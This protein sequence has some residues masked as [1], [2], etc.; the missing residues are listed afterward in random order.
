MVRVAFGLIVFGALVAAR[1]ARARPTFPEVVQ[2]TLSKKSEVSEEASDICP[3]PCSLCHT[4]TPTQDNPETRF[5]LN[6]IEVAN[7]LGVPKT[8]EQLPELLHRLETDPCRRE[9]DPSCATDPCDLCDGDGDGKPDIAELRDNQNPNDSSLLA[10]PMSAAAHPRRSRVIV[11]VRTTERQ[12]S[13]P[14][15]AQ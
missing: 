9:A 13:W 6:L 12:C 1:Q 2:T 8:D 7:A 5:A 14:S 3:P 10:C 4:G 11:A 15:R